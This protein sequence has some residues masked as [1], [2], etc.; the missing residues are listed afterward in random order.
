[1]KNQIRQ[2]FHSPKFTVGFIIFAALLVLTV[3]YPL[4]VTNDPLEMVGQGNFFKPG[5][6]ISVSE[7]VNTN[8][9]TLNLN[10]SS[11]RLEQ[12]LSMEER[13]AMADWLNQFAGISSKEMDVTDAGGLVSLWKDHYDSTSEQKGLIAARKKYFSRLDKKITGLLEDRD[14]LLAEK[15]QETGEVSVKKTIPSTSYV[16]VKD[17]GSRRVFILGTDNFGRDV[18]TELVAAIK[19]SLKIGFIAG[20]IA[21]TI[22]LSLGLIAGYLGGIIDDFILFI[23]NLFTV[24]PSFILLILISYSIGK[25]AR[26]VMMVAFII[27]L[28][29][30]TWTT[31]SVRSQVISLRNR[32]HVNLSKLSGHSLFRI[33]LTDILPYIASYVVMALILQ[34]SSG[35]LAEAQL[36]MI[37]LGPATTTV[38]T[39]GLMMNWAMSYSAHLN[40]DW[41]AY[42]PVI[43]SI[44]LIS[45]SL[46]LMNTGLDQIFNPQLR[47]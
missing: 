4:I 39:L 3:F 28:T 19:T 11:S 24:I 36:S 1:M 20:L 47:E 27:G 40:G 25:N 35:I 7:A 37:G 2:I 34:I 17:V 15:N 29:S 13:M 42:F 9:Y 16:N 45:F 21:T 46:N 33:I 30:W 23:T 6:Y 18:L 22:G 14:V 41:W 26:G 43:I 10:A 12:N 32:D 38:S 5:T 8:P 31:R 44:A